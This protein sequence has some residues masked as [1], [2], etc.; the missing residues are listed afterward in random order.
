MPAPE[1]KWPGKELV[2][3]FAGTPAR[4]SAMTSSRPRD[5]GVSRRGKA[6]LTRTPDLAGLAQRRLRAAAGC[7]THRPVAPVKSRLRARPWEKGFYEL[8]P[9][10]SRSAA[11]SAK[12]ADQGTE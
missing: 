5:G 10:R 6:H 2:A 1:G 3:K 9:A 8:G 7:P 12:G 11:T 4:L